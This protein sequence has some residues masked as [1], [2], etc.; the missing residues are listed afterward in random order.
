MVASGELLVNHH[1][2]APARGVVRLSAP[3]AVP[4]AVEAV[5]VAL[6]A[7]AEGRGFE[8]WRRRVG[9]DAVGLGFA[10]DAAV[11][12]GFGAVVPFLGGV[13]ADEVVCQELTH[14]EE[15]WRFLQRRAVI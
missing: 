7:V 1:A 15:R 6:W 4:D 8:L 14:V 13:A 9:D 10:W 3:A 2:A 12:L 5:E 11:G